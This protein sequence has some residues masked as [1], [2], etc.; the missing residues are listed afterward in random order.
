MTDFVLRFCTNNMCCGHQSAAQRLAKTVPWCLSVATDIELTVVYNAALQNWQFDDMKG[1]RNAAVSN[2]EM[3]AA[4][5]LLRCLDDATT[6]NSQ[7]RQE[8]HRLGSRSCSHMV[9]INNPTADLDMDDC[10]PF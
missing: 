8:L 3:T 1:P 10:L 4:F 6:H 2:E 7:V 5:G 9:L